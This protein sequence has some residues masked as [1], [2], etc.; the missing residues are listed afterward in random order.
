MISQEVREPVP[1]L[2]WR[3][4]RFGCSLA[5]IIAANGQVVIDNL[6]FNVAEAIVER[7]NV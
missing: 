2:P 7:M 5:A 6:N 4:E 3:V 1:P